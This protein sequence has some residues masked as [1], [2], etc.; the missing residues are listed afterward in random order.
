MPK[1][2]KA[3]CACQEHQECHLGEIAEGL[4]YHG[5]TWHTFVVSNSLFHI[6]HVPNAST[7]FFSKF[8]SQLPTC[9][10]AKKQQHLGTCRKIFSPWI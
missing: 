8:F 1:S 10:I 5:I 7:N 9:I 3:E 4:K 6:A 2:N